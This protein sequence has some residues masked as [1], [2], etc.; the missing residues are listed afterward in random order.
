MEYDV[1][2]LNEQVIPKEGKLMIPMD[3]ETL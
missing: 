2:S 1:I 3:G